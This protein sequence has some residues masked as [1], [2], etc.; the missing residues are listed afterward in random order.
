MTARRTSPASRVTV[1]SCIVRY[2]ITADLSQIQMFKILSIKPFTGCKNS[3]GFEGFYYSHAG[4]W[5]CAPNVDCKKRKFV[6]ASQCA[7][8]CKKNCL[9]FSHRASTD[10]CWHYSVLHNSVPGAIPGVP[11]QHI[12]KAYIKCA[13]NND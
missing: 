2:I 9:A 12:Q 8:T 13:G 11:G 3:D 1:V 7:G 5:I 4:G 10:A 6:A